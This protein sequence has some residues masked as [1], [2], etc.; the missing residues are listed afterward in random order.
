[1]RRPS[2]MPHDTKFL[3][4]RGPYVGEPSTGC[5]RRFDGGIAGV[6]VSYT[7][8]S[9]VRAAVEDLGYRPSAAAR[10]GALDMGLFSWSV[11]RSF[12]TCNHV[13]TAPLTVF[14]PRRHQS[15]NRGA[16]PRP[17]GRGFRARESR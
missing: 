16:P 10:G 8:G 9:T 14:P 17:E 3:L 13:Y 6:A 2:S 5:H 11:P 15:Q 4:Q 12:L 7:G 1:M